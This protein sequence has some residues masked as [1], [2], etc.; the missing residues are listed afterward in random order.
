MT[1]LL[2]VVCLLSSPEECENRSLLFYDLKPQVCVMRAQEQL[3]I[4]TAE[5]AGW[6]IVRWQCALVDTT[7]RDI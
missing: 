4:W 3:A 5:H 1:E 6:V 7:S 2:F